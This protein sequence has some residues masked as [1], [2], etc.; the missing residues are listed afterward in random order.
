[1]VTS[2]LPVFYFLQAVQIQDSELMPTFTTQMSPW[3]LKRLKAAHLTFN[4]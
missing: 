1:M 2:V 3:M 4:P